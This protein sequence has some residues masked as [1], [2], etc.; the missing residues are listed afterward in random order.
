M[1]NILITGSLGQVGSE[2]IDYLLASYGGTIY[3]TDVQKEPKIRE[4]S[5][6][7]Y[8]FL[9]V[10]DREAVDNIIR[11]RNID[12]VYHLASILSALVKKTHTLP[13]M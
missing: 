5:R 11:N 12:E 1:T 3:A 7:N 13:T 10:R 6:I 8:E 9:D 4:N 2:L